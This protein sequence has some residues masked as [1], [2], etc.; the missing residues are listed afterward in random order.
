MI[1]MEVRYKINHQIRATSVRIV[2]DTGNQKGVMPIK[3][4]LALAK[5]FNLD[6]IEIAPN[7]NPPVCKIGD[8]GK[9]MY[10]QNKQKKENAQHVIK[11]KEIQFRVNIAD[12]DFQTKINHLKEFL[13]HGHQVKLTL[14]F[15]GR[16]SAHKNLGFEVIQRVKSQLNGSSQMTEPKLTGKNITA[17]VSPLSH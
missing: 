1:K 6:L 16:E 10:S 7:A 12:H 3:E 14:K 9:F 13:T 4:A 15:K 2:E 5:S 8:F 11:S 17:V